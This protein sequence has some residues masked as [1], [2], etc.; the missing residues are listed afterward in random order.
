M[1][2]ALGILAT[3]LVC[4]LGEAVFERR[5]LPEPINSLRTCRLH[6][7]LLGL[8]AGM[9]FPEKDLLFSLFD[10]M[11][12]SLI[13]I[14][15]VWLGFESGLTFIVERLR[16]YSLK[17]GLS[18][19]VQMLCAFLLM[20]IAVT[21]AGP[22]LDTH[23]GVKDNVGLVALVLGTLAITHRVIEPVRG[24]RDASLPH[25]SISTIR[26]PAPANPVALVLLGVL[27]PLFRGNAIVKVG[28]VMSGGYGGTLIAA[29]SVALL[30]GIALDFVFRAHRDGLRCLYLTAGIISIA[31]GVCLHFQVPGIFVGF[32]G[33]A[34]LINTTVRRREALELTERAGEGVKR[35]LFLLIGSVIG[36]YSGGPFVEF[37]SLIPTTV[38]LL[39]LRIAA[40]TIGAITGS[41]FSRQK[42]A[43]QTVWKTG[44]QPLGGLSVGIAVQMLYLPVRFAHNTLIASVLLSVFLSQ[45]LPFFPSQRSARSAEVASSQP[46]KQ[47]PSQG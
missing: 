36:G 4:L 27:F 33:G 43:W 13:A 25:A 14:G 30:M 28:P 1:E 38:A 46:P 16:I 12:H 19:G 26:L 21:V 15:V 24:R 44:W 17:Q 3:L 6:Y 32:A 31:G 47:A 10:R 23:L 8:L 35:L 11:R 18:D 37:P 42:W 45:L 22:T 20:V 29:M 9:L 41:Y 40:R 5:L 39:T 34:W 2:F 7:L